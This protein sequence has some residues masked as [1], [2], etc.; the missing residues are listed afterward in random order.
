MK[1]ILRLIFIITMGILLTGLGGCGK[2]PD[3]A[4]PEEPKVEEPKVEPEPEEPE[5]KEPEPVKPEPEPEYFFSPPSSHWAQT[6]VSAKPKPL[7]G[8]LAMPEQFWFAALS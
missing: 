1:N 5:P 6:T 3:P 4:P 2:E 8:L 7:S